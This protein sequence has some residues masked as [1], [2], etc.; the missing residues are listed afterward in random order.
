MVENYYSMTFPFQPQDTYQFTLDKMPPLQD[1]T[2]NALKLKN[3]TT[4]VRLLLSDLKEGCTKSDA[5]FRQELNVNYIQKAYEIYEEK[6]GWNCIA[7]LH[8]L[9]DN[10]RL[11]KIHLQKFILI[12]LI[13]YGINKKYCRRCCIRTQASSIYWRL[14]CRQWNRFNQRKLNQWNQSFWTVP[15]SS[16]FFKVSFTK[17]IYPSFL[18]GYLKSDF[19]YKPW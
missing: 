14:R 16:S 5:L 6:V 7:N 12:F 9:S 2:N 18:Y 17:M 8:K 3:L 1:T 19:S 4:L 11:C 15:C 13:A 10:S